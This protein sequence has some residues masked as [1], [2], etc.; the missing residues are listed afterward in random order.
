MIR[1]YTTYC[2]FGLYLCFS[3]VAAHAQQ[4]PVYTNDIVEYKLGIELYNKGK[5][6]AA[7]HQFDK[8]IKRINNSDSEISVNSEYYS[9]LCALAL[10][11]KDAEHLLTQFVE[12]HPESPR[13]RN[14]YFQLGRYNYRKK[15][16]ENVINWFEQV[17][18]FDLSSGEVAEYHF[19]KGYSYFMLDDYDN[20]SKILY[21]IKDID[22]KYT[23]PARYYYSHIAY[24]KGDYQTA[25][26]GFQRLSSHEKFAK[27]V[28][29]YITQIYYLQKKYSELLGYAPAL[30]DSATPKRAPEIARLIGDSYYQTK[31]YKESIPYLEKY[32]KAN[33]L[34]SPQD[35]Y[36]LGY[37]NYKA[38]EYDKAVRLFTKISNSNDELAQ[39]AYYHLAD[40]Y[41]KS[42]Q[43]KFARNAYKAATNMDFDTKIQQDALYNYAV[44]SYELSYDPYNKSIEAFLEYIKKYPNAEKTKEAYEYLVNVYMTTNNYRAAMKSIESIPEIDDR[45]K[46]A[47][48]RAAYNSSVAYFDDSKYKS[49]INE[50]KKVRKYPIDKR[51][52]TMSWYWTGEALYKIKQ[53]KK[54][55]EAYQNFIFEPGAILQKE[56][57]RAHYNLGYAYF[58]LEKYSEAIQ[59]FRKFTADK[60]ETNKQLLTDAN[61]RIADSYFL[62]GD[63]FKAEGFYQKA[64]DAKG[65]DIDYAIYQRAVA[66]GFLKKK[67][68]KMQLLE[69]LLKDYPKSTYIVS[70]KLQM[71]KHYYA[72]GDEAKAL[73]YYTDII[74]NYSNKKREY[75]Q[76]LNG[77]AL[78]YYNSN[79]N[80]KA[81]ALFMRILKEFPDYKISKGI[82]TQVKSILVQLDK[83]EDYPKIVENFG[84]GDVALVELD[85]LAYEAANFQ[86]LQSNFKGA[87]K[88]FEKYLTTYENPIF[89]LKANFYKAESEMR[90]GNYEEALKSYNVVIGH[91]QGD[92]TES[93]LVAVSKINFANL[94][95]EQALSN[96]IMLEKVATFSTNI[97]DAKVGQ[98]KCFF[99]MNNYSSAIDYSRQVI[100][101][102][103]VQ[104]NTLIEA[105]I[106]IARSYLAMDS[107]TVA[108]QEFQ[109]AASAT[110]SEIGAESKYFMA[111]IRYDQGDLKGAEAE[112]FELVNR[113][114]TYAFWIA[115]GLILLSDI[116]VETEDLFQAKATLQSI[117][118]NYDGDQGV[119]QEVQE[120]I[121]KVEELQKPEEVEPEYEDIDVDFDGMDEEFEELFEDELEDE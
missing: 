55:I 19:K 95:F 111:K 5:F 73:E 41:I 103:K 29:Y 110:H 118:D 100:S 3:A 70:A 10:F 43:K 18:M 37:A 53:R 38:G 119:L 11:N 17:D 24:I 72:V 51:L 84:Y 46:G 32:R 23:A 45:L 52:N 69:I 4:S 15:R 80:E 56:F 25:L 108:L 83:V 47:Y 81:L 2:L 26:E 33:Y 117:L 9:A 67:D 63:R 39:T 16:W 114:P 61:L 75:Y 21:E 112:V 22:T 27:V 6:G 8:A 49:S 102:E 85:T 93:A 87:K 106:I 62:Q 20:A 121:A 82:L 104:E 90:L 79:K 66:L 97:L 54:A 28:P 86:Y 113:V 116:Y 48:Q 65:G 50:F 88:S 7:Q 13:V 34:I 77:T 36:Q 42:D 31:K 40:C 68:E 91:P 14:V 98:M 76:A 74:E 44:L 57:N 94:D 101:A 115:K 105:Q 58:D 89:K 71:G 59:S 30:L 107:L 120:K 35:N 109:V 78:I 12:N 99:F 96:Y 92:F 1:R 64:I 60:S